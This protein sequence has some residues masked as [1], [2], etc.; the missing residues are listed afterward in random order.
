MILTASRPGRGFPRGIQGGGRLETAPFWGCPG[1]PR[2]AQPHGYSDG[3]DLGLPARVAAVSPSSGL[4][5]SPPRAVSSR[6]VASAPSVF[7]EHSLTRSSSPAVRALLCPLS[8]ALHGDD[9]L[10]SSL[11]HF[12][13]YRR[14]PSVELVFLE[15]LGTCAWELIF[16]SET[17]C[18]RPPFAEHA[19]LSWGRAGFSGCGAHTQALTDRCPSQGPPLP[20]PPGRRPWFWYLA[21]GGGWG[22]TGLAATTEVPHLSS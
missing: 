7:S 16:V 6:A 3:P 18:S 9:R 12:D 2:Q 1:P 8:Q 4:R 11:A 19:V 13:K 5:V 22:M 20:F 14:V 10:L 21:S 15:C 17:F